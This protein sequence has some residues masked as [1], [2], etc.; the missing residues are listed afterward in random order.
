MGTVMWATSGSPRERSGRLLS[1]VNLPY[2]FSSETVDG[3]RL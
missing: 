2:L 3:S 1:K